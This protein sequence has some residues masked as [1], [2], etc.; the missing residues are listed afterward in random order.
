M[1]HLDLLDLL[2]AVVG[3]IAERLNV[4]AGE[5]RHFDWLLGTSAWGRFN[6]I[7]IQ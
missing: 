2:V 1:L 4:N 7:S 3:D 6:F 5:E